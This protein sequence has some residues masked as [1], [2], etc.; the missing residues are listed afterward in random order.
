MEIGGAGT[1]SEQITRRLHR[2]NRWSKKMQ[3]LS[4]LQKKRVARW[5]KAI[6]DSWQRQVHA[7]VTTGLLLIKAH[8]DLISIHGAWSTMVASDLPFNRA[9]AHKLMAIARHPVLASVSHGKRLPASWSTLYQ[10]SLIDATTLATLIEKGEVN[11]KTERQDVERLRKRPDAGTAAT[12]IPPE[13]RKVIE[14]ALQAMQA[15]V[16]KAM[17]TI[18]D[19]MTYGELTSHELELTLTTFHHVNATITE[20]I[21]TVRRMEIRPT[22]TI[23]PETTEAQP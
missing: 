13:K 5:R 20:F 17:N 3:E 23:E 16:T 7:V 14:N 10:L 4:R 8:D 21:A 15:A 22:K 9:T 12:V 6:V 2:V 18:Y 11:P 19:E 1:P